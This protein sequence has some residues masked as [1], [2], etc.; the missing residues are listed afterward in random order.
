M[1]GQLDSQSSMFHY[2]SPQSRVPAEP[3]LRRVKK[4]TNRALGAISA[5]LDTLY[6]QTGRPSIPPERLLKGQ[7]LIALY[8]I[9]T[10]R[11][12]CEQLDD[13][14]LCRWFLDMD[15]ESA[16][17]DQSNFSRLSI[18]RAAT[19]CVDRYRL[20]HRSPRPHSCGARR[21]ARSSSPRSAGGVA[22]SH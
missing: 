8:S 16:S 12:F 2:C 3:P 15:Q 5:E 4:L 7:L 21:V 9:R 14:I 11:Q 6:S 13:N 10:D 17:L 1:R 18:D 20:G 19:R 22:S